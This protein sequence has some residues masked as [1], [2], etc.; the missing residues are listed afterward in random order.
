MSNVSIKFM[1]RWRLLTQLRYLEEIKHPM[2]LGTIGK[3][4]EQKKYKTMGQ[5]ARDIE[6]VFAK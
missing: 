1:K 5:F 4:I 3:K 2:D 6:L